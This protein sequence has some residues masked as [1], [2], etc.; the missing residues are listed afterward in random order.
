MVFGNGISII[1]FAGIISVFRMVGEGILAESK[2]KGMGLVA[3]V[4]IVFLATTAL[5]V[6]FTDPTAEYGSVCKKRNQGRQM[7]R[8]SVLPIYH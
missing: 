3:F 4:V 6:L 5:I 2:D 7:Y 8:Q 1:I